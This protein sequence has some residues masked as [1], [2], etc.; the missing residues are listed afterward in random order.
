MAGRSTLMFLV[1]LMTGCADRETPPADASLDGLWRAERIDG[2]P[3]GRTEF[4]IRVRGGRVV[5][6]KDGCN[7]WG[8]DQSRPPEPNGSRLVVSTCMGCPGIPKISEYWRAIGNGNVI[9][10]LTDQDQL[11]LRAGGHEILARRHERAL[12]PEKSGRP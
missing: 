7:G 9:P 3:V 4:L 11:R 1:A 2:D 10:V 5:G 6:G 12:R 8:F